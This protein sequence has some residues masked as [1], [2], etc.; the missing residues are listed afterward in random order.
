MLLPG[1]GFTRNFGG[2]LGPEMWSKILSYPLVQQQKEVRAQLMN[3]YGF[4][5][6]NYEGAYTFILSR[7][8]AEFSPDAKNALKQA[9]KSAYDD[10]DK[11]MIEEV[12]GIYRNRSNYEVCMS[13]LEK[14]LKTIYP[15]S[16]GPCRKKQY[17]FTLN[18]DL[19]IERT[20]GK[21]NS[22]FNWRYLGVDISDWEKQKILKEQKDIRLKDKDEGFITLPKDDDLGGIKSKIAHEN[23]PFYIK[24]H[25]SYGWLSA[26]SGQNDAMVIGSNKKEDIEKE[27]LLKWYS[28]LFQK[29]IDEG[30]KNLLIIGYGFRDEHINKIL[31]KGIKNNGLKLYVINPTSPKE[32]KGELNDVPHLGM[33][34]TTIWEAIY[35]YFPYRL[36]Q[37]FPGGSLSYPQGTVLVREIY[38]AMGIES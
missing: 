16:F 27:P 25:G 6:E 9:V 34:S 3:G 17:F 15:I 38:K 29:E 2:F 24:L 10:L 20:F 1:A 13:D 12:K 4:N 7:P 26:Q 14:F 19:W 23:G 5:Y 37:I 8:D 22:G 35:G 36:S 33:N 30:D 21:T 18:Q 32:F 28:E 31:V 11:R